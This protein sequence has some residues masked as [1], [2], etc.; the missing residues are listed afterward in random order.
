[1]SLTHLTFCR[2]LTSG[3]RLKGNSLPF[4]GVQLVLCGDFFQL[5]PVGLDQG[6]A[7]FCFNARCWNEAVPEFVIL[8]QVLCEEGEPFRFL[9]CRV[10][11]RLPVKI[12][13]FIRPCELL[14]RVVV[15]CNGTTV[16][17][18]FAIDSGLVLPRLQ[19][20]LSI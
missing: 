17:A 15:G 13:R 4:G 2:V 12:Q 10:C 1:M 18:L 7:D 19:A 11:V 9:S 6:T 3:N 20:C 14:G 8:E 16:K 5:P